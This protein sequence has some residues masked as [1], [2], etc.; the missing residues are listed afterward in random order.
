MCARSRLR[1]NEPANAFGRWQQPRVRKRM[2]RIRNKSNNI[3]LLIVVCDC[4]ALTV[5]ANVWVCDV[6]VCVCVW[7]RILLHVPAAANF[8]HASI[9]VQCTLRMSSD[10]ITRVHTTNLSYTLSVL[11]S[12]LFFII[13]SNFTHKII[14]FRGFI[15]GWFFRFFYFF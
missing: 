11:I 15:F 10:T 13:S 6:R 5:T 1:Q 12:F 8:Y 3:M 14:S 7:E 9:P 4:K 2:R